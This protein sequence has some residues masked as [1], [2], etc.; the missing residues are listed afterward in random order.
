MTSG[1]ELLAVARSMGAEE[2]NDLIGG[3]ADDVRAALVAALLSGYRESDAPLVRALTRHEIDGVGAA[4]DGCGDVLLACCWLLFMLGDV[5]DG[6]L[7]WKAKGLNFD[8][9][10]YLDSVFL[11]PRGIE[12]TATFAKAHGLADLV[13]YVRGDWAGDPEEAAARWRT[14]SFFAQVPAPT[15]SS[16]ELADW[17]RS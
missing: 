13:A 12:A 11:V 15:A 6:A 4:G 14:G 5:A 10:S 3:G 7:V 2:L 1:V 17:I 9:Y 16:E 8:T